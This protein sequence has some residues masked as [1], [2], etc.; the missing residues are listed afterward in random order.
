[1][2]SNGTAT[3][4]AT[5]LTGT[6]RPAISVNGGAYNWDTIDVNFG[7]RPFRYAPPE[8]YKCWN[9]T[10]LPVPAKAARNATKNFVPYLWS[11]TQSGSAGALSYKDIGFQ[12]DFILVKQRNQAYSTG[13]QLYDSVRGFASDKE[14]S[15]EGT[16]A[17]GAGNIED[18]GWI[19]GTYENGF[20]TKGGPTNYD[21]VNLTGNNYVA[22]C[23]S[24]PESFSNT[25][26]SNGADLA[27]TGKRNVDAGF[28]IVSWT[29]DGG[30]GGILG[31][32]GGLPRIL[33]NNG[34]SELIQTIQKLFD[35]AS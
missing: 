6:Y 33:T 27:C 1:M 10:N 19:N 8:G 35:I 24:A 11:G 34:P 2:V 23:W 28:T 16:A 9:R 22:W 29:S 32:L 7:Q 30:T 15:S 14:I 13:H 20:I 3:A 26:G 25:A 18:Y 21:Y 17:Q 4:A 5:G 12:P 31:G